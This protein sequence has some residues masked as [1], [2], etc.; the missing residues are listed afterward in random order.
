MPNAPVPIK[1]LASAVQN[2]V[3]QVLAQHGAVPV[4]KLW[5]GFVAPE[6]LATHDNASKVAAQ[7]GKEAGVNVQASVAQLTAASGAEKPAAHEAQATAPRPGHI[8]GLVFS[9]R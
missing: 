9:P 1:E 2:A 5:V 8:I 7:L 6:N 4:E 3:Q